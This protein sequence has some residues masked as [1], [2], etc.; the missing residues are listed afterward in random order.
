MRPSLIASAWTTRKS[1]STVRILPF[2]TTVS[3]FCCASAAMVV[4]AARMPLQ[5]SRRL[6]FAKRLS[7]VFITFTFGSLTDVGRGQD[8]TVTL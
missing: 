4:S 7:G 3:T 1:A 6:S 5:A 2:V 8:A